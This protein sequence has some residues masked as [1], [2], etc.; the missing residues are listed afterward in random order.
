M[1]TIIMRPNMKNKLINVRDY[2]NQ[3]CRKVL[4]ASRLKLTWKYCEGG[5]TGK[6]GENEALGDGGNL[7]VFLL[8]F[9]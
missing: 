4:K 9:L 2:H 6:G 1:W 8:T 3:K 5:G 7:L